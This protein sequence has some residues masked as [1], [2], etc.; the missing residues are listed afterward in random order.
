MKK[1]KYQQICASKI[2]TYYSL[3]VTTTTSLHYHV[4]QIE[5]TPEEWIKLKGVLWLM[6]LILS[7]IKNNMVREVLPPK[8]L[9]QHTIF[10]RE[11]RRK[12]RKTTGLSPSINKI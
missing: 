5:P 7:K 11:K 9:V 2:I 10:S 6:T 4:C 1:K 12:N 3:S 8:I